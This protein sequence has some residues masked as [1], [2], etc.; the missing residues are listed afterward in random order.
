MKFTDNGRVT[1]TARRI[2]SSEVPKLEFAVADTGIG[3]T[4]Q[5]MARLFEDFAQGDDSTT[6]PYGGA[7]LGLAITRRLA[8]LMGGDVVVESTPGKGSVFKLSL[9]VSS[10]PTLSSRDNRQ[11][12]VDRDTPEITNYRILLTDDNAV[13]RKVVRMFMKPFGVTLV[14]VRDGAEA[15]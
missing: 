13:N 3:M 10:V 7:G 2:G 15:L 8:R 9:A 11:T 5:H 6:R 1:V 14:E 12:R 4:E